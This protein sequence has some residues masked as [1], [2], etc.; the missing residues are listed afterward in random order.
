MPSADDRAAMLRR[1]IDDTP[2][3]WSTINECDF[4]LETVGR[5]GWREGEAPKAYDADESMGVMTQK[6]SQAR[7]IERSQ[8]TPAIP[9]LQASGQSWW[10]TCLTILR[11][12]RTG[13]LDVHCRIL[14]PGTSPG[15]EPSVAN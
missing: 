2:Q 12:L 6:N 11:R 9:N 8:K 4:S 5:D 15:L 10:T 3:G 13:P 14:H 7:W 1:L